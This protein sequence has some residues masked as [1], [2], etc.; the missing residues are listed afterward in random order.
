VSL[1]DGAIVLHEG[2]RRRTE[3]L[4]LSRVPFT[5][6]GRVGFQVANALAAVA[7]AWGAGM[8]PA[9][10]ARALTTFKSDV[11]TVPGRF[12]VMNF[13]GAEVVLDYGH[14]EAA[15]TALGEA[16]GALDKRRTLMVLGLPGDRRDRD[17][18]ATVS[19][20][21]PF[22]DEYVLH[23][24]GDRRDR[25]KD[26]VPHLLRQRIPSNVPV[27]IADNQAHAVRLAWRRLHP[28]ERMIVIADVVDEA[29]E[30]LKS[31]DARAEDD[32]SCESPL[33]AVELFAKPEPPATYRAHADAH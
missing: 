27:E 3:L 16:V 15:M 20:T 1:E 30:I 29:I 32:A 9:L 17:L 7:A 24:L 14:N 18:V 6:G 33:T 10:I 4:E 2:E 13:N 5:Y 21:L 25:A 23:D 11:A 26:E 22:V 28:G 12:N 19:A 8:N 31:I